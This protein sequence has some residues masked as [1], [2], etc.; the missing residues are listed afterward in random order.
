MEWNPPGHGDIYAALH[1]SGLLKRFLE[2]GIQYAFIANSDNLGATL[3][4][5]LLGF[6]ASE[7]LP[8]MMEVAERTPTDLKGGHLARHKSGHLVLREIAQCP[9]TEI[10][11]FQDLGRYGYF[12]TNNIWVNLELL[13][14]VITEKGGGFLPI[15]VNP[16]ALDPRDVTSPQVYQIETAMGAAIAVFHGAKAVKVS[17]NRFFPVKKCQD[18]LALRSDC[19][20]LTEDGRLELNPN[21]KLGPIKITLD[22]SYYGYIDA[23]EQRFRWIPSL[24]ACESLYIQGNVFFEKDVNIIGRVKITNTRDM[25][26]TIESTTIADQDLV[27]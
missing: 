12:N 15:I 24:V 14:K 25:P 17:E 20:Q 8:F 13:Y 21:R 9:E 19:Y 16:K 2:T 4:A 18:L 7:K 26:L 5:P 11:A 23:L 1:T 6:F 10:S 27:F 22:D 3:D